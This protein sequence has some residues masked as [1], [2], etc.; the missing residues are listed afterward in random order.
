MTTILLRSGLPYAFLRHPFYSDA[1]VPRVVGD[2]GITSSTG[3]RGLNTAF[4]SRWR[5][6]CCRGLR[7]PRPDIV[8]A[9]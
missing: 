6:T 5:R 7:R 8:R 9:N 2:G 4:R 1:F 3:G